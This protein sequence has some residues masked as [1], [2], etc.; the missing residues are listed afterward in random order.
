MLPLRTLGELRIKSQVSL[1]PFFFWGG[2]WPA[3]VGATPIC[4]ICLWKKVGKTPRISLVYLIKI[5]IDSLKEI[6]YTENLEMSSG[7]YN[8]G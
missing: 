1:N 5:K 6:N 4:W 8:L 7:N 3:V 2:E